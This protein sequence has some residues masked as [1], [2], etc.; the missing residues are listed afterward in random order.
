MMRNNRLLELLSKYNL[1]LSTAESC[2]GGLISKKI[3]DIS[4]SSAVFDCGVCSYA[5]DIKINVL[6]VKR[7]TIEKYGAVSAQTAGEMAKGALLLSGA[8]IA[9]STTGI[10]G[11]TGGT[12]KK[13]VGL[14]YICVA[15]RKKCFIKKCLFNASNQKSR[16]EI[17]NLAANTAL[18]LAIKVLCNY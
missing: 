14:V 3:T 13:P 4:G 2:T 9:I 5:N 10:A 7:D 16:G 17:R 12:D 11:P 18:S 8:D 1:K 15:T 6:G